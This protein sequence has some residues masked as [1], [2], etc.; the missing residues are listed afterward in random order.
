MMRL[1]CVSL[2]PE[3]EASPVRRMLPAFWL[4]CHLNSQ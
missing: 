1:A 3:A 2:L 4:S